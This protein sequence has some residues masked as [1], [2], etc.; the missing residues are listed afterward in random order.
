[1]SLPIKKIYIDTKYKTKDSVSNS[2][3]KIELPQ[4]RLMSDNT[5]FTLTIFQFRIHG[6]LYQLVLIINFT[7]IYQQVIQYQK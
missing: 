7:F 6:T 3:F 4:T 1:M 2:H 5:V